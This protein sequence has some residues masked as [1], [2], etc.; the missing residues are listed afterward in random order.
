MANVKLKSRY[1]VASFFLVA[2]FIAATIFLYKVDLFTLSF[3]IVS[4]YEIINRLTIYRWLVIPMG[5]IIIVFFISSY[6]TKRQEREKDR[7][8]RKE[9]ESAFTRG[10]EN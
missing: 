8:E 10:V 4:P 2:F 6:G 3:F 5:V 7:E 9:K 1:V